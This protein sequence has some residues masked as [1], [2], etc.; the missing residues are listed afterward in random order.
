MCYINQNQSIIHRVVGNGHEPETCC[1]RTEQHI[2]FTWVLTYLPFG[3]KALTS[4]WVYKTKY[5]PDGSV[6]RHKARLVIKGFEQV[7][8]KDYMRTFSPVAKL[9]TV[10]VFIAMAT[11]KDWPVHQLDINNA[12]LHGNL[13]E[14]VYMLPPEGYTKAKPSQV[15]KLQRSFYG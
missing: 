14:E 6:E 8:E 13:N 9:T 3:K 2:G 4:K 5:K 10:R 7:K 12:F 1:T 15:S 11:A